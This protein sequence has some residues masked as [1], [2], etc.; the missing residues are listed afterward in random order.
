VT[1][2]SFHAQPLP[3]GVRLR[4]QV[5][6][7]AAAMCAAGGA[8]ALEFNTGNP[9]LAVRW[10]NTVRYNLSG[11]AERRD[12][13]IANYSTTDE[14]DNKF[15]GGKIVNNRLDIFSELDMVYQSRLGARLSAAGWYDAGYNDH[16]VP[17]GPNLAGR[18]S[19]NNDTYSHTVN[20]YYNGPSGELL[21]AFVFGNFDIAGKPVRLKVGKHSIFWGD[22]VFNANH[23]V[24]YSQ[25]PGDT[26]KQLSSPGI[27]AKETV[28][29]V[30]Q[31]SGQI[32]LADTLSLAGQYFLDW[33][34]NRN[35]EGGTY[36]G[37]A[38]FLFDGPDHFS[39]APGFAVPRAEAV[40]PDKKRGNWGINLKWSPEWLDGT[41]G[42]YY[43]EFDE[44]QPWSTPQIVARPGGFYRLSYPRG[45]RLVGLG[46]NKNI[47]GVA[48]AM[49]VSKRMNT[50]FVN[51]G[52]TS[53]SNIGIDPVTLEGARGDSYHGFVNATVLGNLGARVPFTLVG[54]VVAS[55]WER[56]TANPNLFKAEG[57][58]GCGPDDAGLSCVTK[59]YMGV[60]LLFSPKILQVI[61]SGDL[62]IPLFVT[63][64]IKGNAATLSGGNQGAGTYSIGLQLD[65]QQRYTFG[66]TYSD[67][68]GKYKTNAAGT[69][70]AS[71]GPLYEDRG[72]LA[73]NFKTSF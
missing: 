62:S 36:Y 38:D 1:L 68:L 44:R 23:S 59:N 17:T 47:G 35:P 58:G 57:Y 15:G 27:E 7:A 66:L 6:V 8:S 12:P 45:T 32:Q 11:R 37:A 71:N 21:D 5:A 50:A 3:C 43:R 31:I 13:A 28:L 42:V 14:S 64:G 46:L 73:F 16:S 56:V 24:A 33:K 9:D 2:T 60:S 18:G 65:Y 67:F 29:P 49:E 34:P 39:L 61:P 40:E 69:I 48:V 4:K 10:D 20:R 26:R 53:A 54:E 19:Y 30:A 63:Y 55:H 51:G 72:L 22:V 52:A 41:L 70:I 25:M